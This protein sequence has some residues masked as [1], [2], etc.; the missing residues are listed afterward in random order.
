MEGAVE[1]CDGLEERQS[2]I[3][4]L[5]AALEARESGAAAHS[6][7]V[8]AYARDMALELQL[9]RHRV[10]RLRIAGLLHDVGKIGI[11]DRILCKPGPLTEPEWHEMRR[12][13]EIG[14][15]ILAVSEFDDVREWIR[16]HHE[17]PDGRGYPDGVAAAEVALEARVLAVADA[18]EAMVSDRVYRPALTFE[19]ALL[20]LRDGAG[21][22]F[23]P[24][25]VAALERVLRRDH[26]GRRWPARF[27]RAAP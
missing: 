15:R 25:V 16:S 4:T 27:P 23:D 6:L 5:A 7:R 12:H 9:P 19:N 20:E 11:A 1:E 3:V 17:R 13:P 18:W 8:A 24:Q 10:E 22:Q 21:T 26:E 2:V 14:A